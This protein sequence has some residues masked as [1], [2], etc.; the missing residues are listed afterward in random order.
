MICIEDGSYLDMSY[1]T[2]VSIGCPC[3]GAPGRQSNICHR[4]NSSDSIFELEAG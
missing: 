1:V 3:Q 2:T 4:D